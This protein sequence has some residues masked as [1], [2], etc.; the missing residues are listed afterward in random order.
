MTAVTAVWLT[1]HTA[2]W[3][4][5]FSVLTFPLLT[6]A[7]VTAIVIGVRR[8]R[9]EVSA[10]WYWL[11]AGFALFLVGGIAR[12]SLHTLGDLTTHRSLLPD[13]ITIPG[14]I[15]SAIG[16]FGIARAR[17]RGRAS[18]I[19]A[20]LDASVAALAA[21]ALGWLFV[22]NPTEIKHSP[23]D[24]RMVLAAYPTMSVFLVAVTASLAFSAGTRKI[25]ANK[26]LLGAMV[27]VL[28]GDLVY[29]LLET[30]AISLPHTVVDL[31]YATGY[32]FIILTV[33]HPSMR[34]LTDPVPAVEDAPTMGRLIVVA[35]ALAIPGLVTVTRVDAPVGD[36]IAMAVI[37]LS[38]TAAAIT[39]LFRAVRAHAQSEARL[40]HQATHD[41]LT[42][43]PNRAYVQEFLGQALAAARE[44]AD[45]RVALLFL[46]V[47]RFKLVN[48][49]YGH[50][51]GDA[52]LL[53]VAQRLRTS[54]RPTDLVGRVGGDEFVIVAQSIQSG[55]EASEIAHRTRRLFATAFDVAG[56]EL[57]SSVSI[58]VTVADGSDPN[59]DAE[60]MIRDADTAMYQAKDSGRD[61]VAVFDASM[62][63]KVSRRLDLE[64]DLHHALDRHELEL[65]YQ[66]VVD[67]ASGAVRGFEALLRWNHPAWGLI[68]PLSFIPVAEETGLIVD[69][70]GW[71]LA[72][73][74]RQ[75]Q[76]WR[77]ELPHGSEM[78]IAVNV[79]ARQLRDQSIVGRV[80]RALYE[81]GL[82]REALTLELTESTLMENPAGA[83]ELLGRL[84]TLGV[85][86]A[87]DDFGTGYSSLAYLRRFPVDVVKIDRAF[88]M[89]LEQDSADATLIAAIVAMSDALGVTTIAEG[90]ESETQAD[91]LLALGC[92]VAQGYLYSR[93]VPA[94]AVPDAVDRLATRAKGR[95]RPVRDVYSA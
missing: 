47:D 1:A 54:I 59:V 8:Y 17:Q 82:P 9:P 79:S 43:L 60:T 18:E 80:Q 41:M 57:A 90:V 20:M 88:V 7:A 35:V 75:M 5:P 65:H 49:T 48:D 4:G 30:H 68:S 94:A 27:C 61:A 31:P 14:Y 13:L 53:A 21:M 15:L 85:G 55:A 74:C 12:A 91:H 33:L 28:L 23:L 56:A 40:I 42:G 51:L 67:I 16:L 93:P 72:E 37:V 39:R 6:I 46:D 69:I 2:G 63:D 34:E 38:L 44:N 62:R 52:F 29:I 22:I 19:D 70:G 95:L 89:D 26:F 86:L 36:R 84:K 64:R 81:S 32:L 66:P 25:L 83:P 58:G 10:P 45:R 77:D 73:A 87:I 24:V 92:S 71:V 50:T 78:S 3:L 76:I 11:A